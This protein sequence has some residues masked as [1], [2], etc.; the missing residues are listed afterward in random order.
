MLDKS[1][2][3]AISI[4]M[5]KILQITSQLPRQ[6]SF[7]LQINVGHLCES[8]AYN[9]GQTSSDSTDMAYKLGIGFC[10]NIL[11]TCPHPLHP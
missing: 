6:E 2:R 9:V 4:L 10:I 3:K 1:L 8:L 5:S 11:N 7:I